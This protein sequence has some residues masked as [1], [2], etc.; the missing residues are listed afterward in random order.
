MAFGNLLY[1][2]LPTIGGNTL[3]FMILGRFLSGF[4]SGEQLL[5]SSSKNSTDLIF[6]NHWCNACLY[7]N[8]EYGERSRKGDSTLHR[9]IR[10]GRFTRSSRTSRIPADHCQ[11]LS[12]WC[13]RAEY[14]YTAVLCH[15]YRIDC[16]D[17]TAK[18]GIRRMLFGNNQRWYEEKLVWRDFFFDLLSLQ[19]SIWCY[20]NLTKL[21]LPYA[22]SLG[23]CIRAIAQTLKCKACYYSIV[24]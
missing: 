9:I 2:L 17:D 1:G 23:S 15:R 10:I 21:P 14:V 12:N 13:N 7:G 4:G 19:T 18:S 3:W 11:W 16:I 20:R 5:K 8:S 24:K 6:R 22:F